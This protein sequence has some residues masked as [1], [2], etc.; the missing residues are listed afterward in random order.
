MCFRLLHSNKTKRVKLAF[1]KVLLCSLNDATFCD[2]ALLQEVVVLQHAL[3]HT[4]DVE[5]AMS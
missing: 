5:E 2:R 3:K 4:D 1:Q